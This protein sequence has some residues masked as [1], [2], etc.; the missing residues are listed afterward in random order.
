MATGSVTLRTFL[1]LHF[2]WTAPAQSWGQPCR[3]PHRTAQR[4]AWANCGWKD[5]FDWVFLVSCGH[6]RRRE[7]EAFITRGSIQEVATA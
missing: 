4:E 6:I 1:T 7:Q 3:H 5:N 2:Y